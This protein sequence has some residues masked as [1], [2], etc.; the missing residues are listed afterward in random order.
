MSEKLLSG[1][2]DNCP[3]RN[4]IDCDAAV[5]K[6]AVTHSIGGLDEWSTP[7]LQYISYELTDNPDDPDAQR[8][9]IQ[10]LKS[11]EYMATAIA[12]AE[13]KQRQIDQEPRTPAYINKTIEDIMHTLGAEMAVQKAKH[14]SLKESLA[15]SITDC[16]GPEKDESTFFLRR[17]KCGADILGRVIPCDVMQDRNEVSRLLKRHGSVWHGVEVLGKHKPIR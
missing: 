15:E 1:A 11:K 2:C 16:E 12:A 5:V 6:N 10:A 3:L 7:A 17:K 9:E 8:Y 14:A 4:K 13:A